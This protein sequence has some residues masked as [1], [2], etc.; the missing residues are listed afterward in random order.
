MADAIQFTVPSADFIELTGAGRSGSFYHQGGEGSQSSSIIFVESA[1][2][3]TIDPRNPS[4][5]KDSPVSFSL[6][7]GDSASY[8][9][10]TTVWAISARD[11]QL[12]TVTP[13]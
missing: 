8:S 6:S 9:S 12:L 11:N 3:P 2:K 4:R 5:F 10:A 1:A 7:S 13:A